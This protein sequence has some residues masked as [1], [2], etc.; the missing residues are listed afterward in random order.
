MPTHPDILGELAARYGGCDPS[1]AEDVE[2]FYTDEFRRLPRRQRDR[3][4]HEILQRDGE[5]APARP[6]A[7]DE[8]QQLDRVF[9]SEDKRS[10][11]PSAVGIRRI[12]LAHTGFSTAI[13]LVLASLKLAPDLLSGI[14]PTTLAV[15][16]L[17][18]L[19]V[20]LLGSVAAFLYQRR[21]TRHRGSSDG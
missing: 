2:R 14:G 7:H 21:T 3:I 16:D 9:D 11:F 8:I 5:P 6:L 4:S 10:N 1:S 18:L 20:G 19:G 17:P 12:A 13:F 15:L